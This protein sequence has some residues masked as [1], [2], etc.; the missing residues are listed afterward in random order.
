MANADKGYVKLYRSIVDWQ[1]YRDVPTKVLYLHLL[2]IANWN[3]GNFKGFAVKRGEVVRSLSRLSTETGLTAA[4]CRTAIA[5]LLRTND[6]TVRRAGKSRI[7]G[8]C[9]FEERQ[10]S[11]IR[12]TMTAETPQEPRAPGNT[13]RMPDQRKREEKSKETKNALRVPSPAAEWEP[14]AP[15]GWD[16]GE[17]NE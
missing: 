13:E 1:W 3:E 9:R 4:Q 5:H 2:M 15:E 10:V 17:W 8:I 11:K 7:I 14:Q 6:V 12:R 16:D